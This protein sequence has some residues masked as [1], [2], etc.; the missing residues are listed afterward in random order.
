MAN[1][2]ESKAKFKSRFEFTTRRPV[3]ILMIVLGIFVFGLVSYN[4]LRWD[5]M[6]EI[7]YPSFTVRTEYPGAAPEEVEN[8]VSR[9]L[10]EQLSLIKDLVSITSISR[11]EQS[12]IILEFNWNTNLDRSA[13]EIREK[14]DQVFL[15]PAVEKPLIL[16]Y[17]P[18]L[19][20]VLRIGIVSD[21]SLTDLRVIVEDE[22]ARELEALTGVAAARV[23]GGYEKEILIKLDEKQLA[24]TKIPFDQITNRLRQENVNLAGGNI[25]EGETEY[26]VRTLNEFRS[27]NEIG[28][29]IITKRGDVPMRL[30]DIAQIFYSHK[31]RTVITRVNKLESIEVDIFKE[32]DANIVEVS[33]RVKHRLFGT[34]E[35]QQYVKRLQ[36]NAEKD[37]GSSKG[38]EV[39][40]P[41]KKRLTDF[42]EYRLSK[43]GQQIKYH[44]LADQSIFIE[45]SINEV[46]NT[47]FIGGI[48]AFLVL[49]LF[50]RHVPTTLIVAV[51]IP[52]SVIAAFAPLRLFNV[53]LNIMSLGGLA[54]GIGMLVDNS[55]VV[56]ESIFR[57]REEGD[58][59]VESAV[60]GVSEV[61]GAVIASTL[62]TIAVFFPIVFV[63]GIAGQIFGDL[64]LAVVFSLL[65][66]LMV[67]LFFIPM[68]ASRK[69]KKT[70]DF[71]LKK[72]ALRFEKKHSLLNYILIPVETSL[73]IVILI[74]KLVVVL[75]LFVISVFLVFLYP[76]LALVR[77]HKKTV[78]L[79]KNVT[80][81]LAKGKTLWENFMIILPFNQYAE[82]MSISKSLLKWPFAWLYYIF[83]F[84]ISG[85]SFVFIRFFL[86]FFG[87]AVVFF[88]GFLV[89]I[90]TPAAAVL[91]LLA[92]S[93]S[94]LL[95]VINKF[96]PRLLNAALKNA[97][98]VIVGVLILFAFTIFVVL[99]GIGSEL[100]P[101]VH[102]GTIY[103]NVTFPVGT[104][105]EKNDEL[106]QDISREIRQDEL[107]QEIS[108][109]AG[110]TKDELQE[111]EVGE[112][113]GRITVV[114]K[115]SRDIKKTEER[116]ITNLRSL[117]GDFT[118]L[119]YNISRPVL[120][121]MK[122]P[123]EVVIKGYNLAELRR[124]SSEIYQRIAEIP[125][126][127]DVQSS[128]K[129][130][131]PELVVEFDRMRLSHY[132]MNAFD[133]AS[134]IKNKIEGFVATKYKEKDR[135]IDIRVYLK[136][137]QRRRAEN[138]K[139][140]IINPGGVVP[141]P[142]SSVASVNILSGP[143]EIRRVDQERSAII[144]A[145]ISD[146]NLASAVGKIYD[147]VE[148]YPLPPGFNY[149]LTGQNK[150]ME[151]SLNSLTLA[152]VLAI[153]LVYIV[154]ASQF[155]SLLHPFLILFTIPMALIG[156]FLTLYV[157]RIPIGITVYIG[158]I[159]LVG[160]VVN[161]AIILIDYI[162]T[163]RKR[164]ME[165]LEAIKQAGAVRLRPILI[166]TLTTVLGL[167]PMAIGLGEGTEIR[168]PMAVSIIAGLLSA[169]FLTLV[170]IPIAYSKFSK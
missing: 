137:E 113:I 141:I 70:T 152:M 11:P 63:E 10:E 88:K 150:E 78:Q 124:I 117:L 135:R 53:S 112:H 85:F 115:K 35:Q 160:I 61:G 165:K 116:F 20:P 33:N 72:F 95:K 154:M 42:L 45:N 28:D 22:I 105:V 170:L 4:Q 84:I 142:L 52:L 108:Y 166:T 106:L 101:E 24:A 13:Q 77:I 93:F 66:S 131:F 57:C 69:F 99:P 64:S 8:V 71:S 40:S 161:N 26:I 109:Y 38:A 56:M 91:K 19:D 7:S 16:R 50:L 9:P 97:T 59:W 49:F 98:Q 37:K 32:A 168:M 169:T 104:P 103:V 81:R 127:K 155:E 157:L 14:L 92:N 31:E 43:E 30:K 79:I 87:I 132:S 100:I 90:L 12:D 120:F 73:N 122:P 134:L 94:K 111:D 102:Q 145:N 162:N 139:S 51:A 107:V 58:G 89:M 6:P 156:V 18:S 3:A 48:L 130:G 15:D 5:L 121:T 2:S 158:M 41:E 68:L 1:E 17:D 54:L 74:L 148:R 153:F 80:E 39:D 25:K 86:T 159:T 151:T 46:K 129:P 146:I 123:I 140:L 114:L 21:I 128:V 164:G 147:V 65:A 167:L 27:V 67:S 144:S 126:L 83:R 149:E 60:R 29:I 34:L 118:D 23:K 55:I 133:V 62:T 143:N 36:E 44:I 163:L 75:F 110:T 76:L 119:D 136:D 47:A 96:Y 82:S 138:I 125:G